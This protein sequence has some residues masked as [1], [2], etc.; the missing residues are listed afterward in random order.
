LVKTVGK[1]IN[2]EIMSY[3]QSQTP[4]EPNRFGCRK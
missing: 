3:L 2:R 4:E 1:M